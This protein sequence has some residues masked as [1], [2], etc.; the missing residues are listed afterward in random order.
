[1]TVCAKCSHITQPGTG[2]PAWQCPSCGIAYHKYQAYLEKIRQDVAPMTAAE[3]HRSLPHDASVWSL[4]LVNVIA[5]GVALAGGWSLIDLMAVYWVQSVIIGVSYFF[6]IMGLERFST[7]NFQINDR[8]VD[9][10]PETKRKTAFF[11]LCHY[12]FF[13]IGYLVFIMVENPQESPWGLGLAVCAIAFAI[14]HY[15]SYRYHRAAD[16][17][18]ANGVLVFGG[19]KLVADVAM[20]L[21]EHRL[22]SRSAEH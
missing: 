21:A 3:R 9:P 8:D 20:H 14:N 4:V 5:L 15:Y 11:F 18:G 7:R 22:L 2:A 10:T 16:R 1:M 6:R 13:H 12:G 17:S 19:M